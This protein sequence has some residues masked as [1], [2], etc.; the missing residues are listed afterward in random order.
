MNGLATG[1]DKQLEASKAFRSGGKSEE[2]LG[3]AL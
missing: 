2:A 3:G 1:K